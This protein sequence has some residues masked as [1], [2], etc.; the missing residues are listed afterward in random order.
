MRWLD[1]VNQDIKTLRMWRKSNDCAYKACQK[2]PKPTLS[3][4]LREKLLVPG[5]DN[6]RTS[7]PQILAWCKTLGVDH[8]AVDSLVR[9]L[10]EGNITDRSA[11]KTAA[12]GGLREIKQAAEAAEQQWFAG[13]PTIRPPEDPVRTNNSK[14]MQSCDWIIEKYGTTLTASKR[15]EALKAYKKKYRRRQH[16]TDDQLR[17]ALYRRGVR[18]PKT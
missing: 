18:S 7:V 13:E 9:L 12:D 10:L 17:T 5:S 2:E 4:F 15:R 14:W 11:I 6:L 1:V 16:P 3:E 8:D